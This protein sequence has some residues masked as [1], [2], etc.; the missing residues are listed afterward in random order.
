[1]AQMAFLLVT[2]LFAY[3]IYRRF[4]LIK[5][6]IN[7]GKPADFSDN[8]AERFKT[9][10]LIAFGQK[11]MFDKPLVGFMHLIIYLGFVIINIELLE[12]VLDGLTGQHRLFLPVIGIDFYRFLI[13]SFEWLALGVFA[14][15]VVFFIRR[16]ALAIKRFRQ[17]E[18]KGWPAKDANTI[19][20]YECVLMWLFLSM[21]AADANLQALADPH[22][23]LTGSFVISKFIQPIVNFGGNAEAIHIYERTAWWLHIIGIFGFA[24]YLSWSK[25][26]HVILAFPNVYFSRLKPAGEINN[27]PVIS[28]EVKSMLGLSV[29]GMPTPPA[30]PARFGANDVTDLTWK[31][32][33][34]AYSCTECGR[35]TSACPANMTGKLLSPRKIMMDTRDRAQEVAEL[36]YV[37]EKPNSDKKSLYQDFITKEELMACTTC[38]ACVD[39]CPININ[40]LEII[41]EMRRYV[42]LEE[43]ATPASWN[44]MF[45]NMENNAAPWAFPPSDRANWT[46]KLNG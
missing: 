32:I 38:N 34:E 16:N 15:C 1:M 8:P 22:Y 27:M 35:C 20:I 23:P 33:M 17:P 14:V 43:S 41:L 44:S 3:F 13:N 6:A 19:L 18:L 39:A 11:K 2:A 42:A 45:Q 25:H 36:V 24:L 9:M 46:E 26:L 40:P 37:G 29:E 21:N 12:I 30:E 31:N 4:T 28:Y 10:A 7:L 5:L